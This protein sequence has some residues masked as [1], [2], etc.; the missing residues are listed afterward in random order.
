MLQLSVE[1]LTKPAVVTIKALHHFPRFL[2]LPPL[3]ETARYRAGCG[4]RSRSSM[5]PTTQCEL[6]PSFN[7]LHVD[8]R[9]D[10]YVLH[11][12]DWF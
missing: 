6:G 9:E 8:G 12:G 3:A 10:V 1:P 7:C 2:G 11:V 5:P 4:S